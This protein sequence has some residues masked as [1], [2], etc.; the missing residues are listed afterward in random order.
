MRQILG[1]LILIVILVGCEKNKQ[2]ES[3]VTEKPAQVKE[4][5]IPDG[6][7][8]EN[9]TE[10]DTLKGSIKSYAMAEAGDARLVITYHSPAVRGRI[11]WGG[12]VPLDQVWVTGAHMAT[13]FES[14][15]DFVMGDKTITA[16][17]YALFT[18]PGKD[19]WTIILNKNWQ[20][21]LTDEYKMDEDIV[22]FTITPQVMSE[23]QERLQYEIETRSSTDIA[24]HIRWEKLKVTVPLT[25]INP[26]FD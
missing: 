15:Y 7:I 3:Q 5:E 25:I 18:I 1:V 13:T 9:Q 16:G 19:K 6:K 4:I 11:I 22:R 17:R 23:N 20:Q 2:P 26:E 14:N 12:L 24:I 21:H 10:A 8:I